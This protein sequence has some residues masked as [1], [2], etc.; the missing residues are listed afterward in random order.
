MSSL[1]IHTFIKLKVCGL[2]KKSFISQSTGGY[3]NPNDGVQRDNNEEIIV[4]VRGLDIQAQGDIMEIKSFNPNN[5]KDGTFTSGESSARKYWCVIAVEY[6]T[7]K[8]GECRTLWSEHEWGMY[9]STELIWMNEYFYGKQPFWPMRPWD[10][11]GEP[12][13]MEKWGPFS[14]W[15]Y[16][17]FLHISSSHNWLPAIVSHNNGHPFFTPFFSK[18]A[19]VI[20][21]FGL[22]HNIVIL[23][24]SHQESSH[25]HAHV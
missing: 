22:M 6:L 14:F 25:L 23:A 20:I 8:L 11:Y 4:K 16:T 19:P 17:T 2:W 21:I 13:L 18:L 10:W 9:Y 5:L 15:K 12:F 1:L 3:V 7:V 24:A